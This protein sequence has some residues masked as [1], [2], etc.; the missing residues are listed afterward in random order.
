MKAINSNRVNMINATIVFCDGN[1]IVTMSIPAFG[2][3]LATIKAKMLL[4]NSYNQIGEGT[5]KGVTLD[6]NALREVMTVLALKCGN[7]TLAYANSVKNNTLAALVNYNE[8]A[9]DKMKKEDVD[10]ACKAI[11]DATNANIAAVSGFGVGGMDLPDLDVAISLYRVASQNPRQAVITK[12]QAKKQGDILVRE[13]IDELLVNQLDKMVNTLK[14]SEPAFWSGYKQSREIID[15][16]STS[17]KV[18]G[19][20]LDENDVPLRNVRFTILKTG[21]AEVVA[22]VLTDIKG[23]FNAAKL[24]AGDFDFKWVLEGYGTVEELNVHIAAGKELKRKVVMDGV[25]VQEGS[26]AS[27]G[28]A[29]ITV[30]SIDDGGLDMIV[31]EAKNSGMRFY[32]TNDPNNGAGVAFLDVLPGQVI[33]K[34]GFEFGALVGWGNGNGYLNVENI[35]GMQGDWKITF[36][37]LN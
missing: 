15:L 20:V 3:L 34:T 14:A 10:D 31:V 18:R 35:G 9:L 2:V 5:T 12:S 11:Y 4:V 13:V 19:T 24:P 33:S 27:G 1:T 32:A 29:N 7:A 22:D 25:V 21:T 23:K 16:G 37:G 36:E 26:L 17:T 6:T 30:S 28:I 8:S